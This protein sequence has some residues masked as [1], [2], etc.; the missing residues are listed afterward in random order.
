MFGLAIIDGD[1]Y[2]F[3]NIGGDI[4]LPS[5]PKFIPL[6]NYKVNNFTN[7]HHSHNIK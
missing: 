1:N 2:M 4:S 6:N 7:E 3:P 5:H